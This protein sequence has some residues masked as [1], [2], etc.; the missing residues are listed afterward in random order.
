[1][2]FI[3]VIASALCLAAALP[4]EVAPYGIAALGFICLSPYFAVLSRSSSYKR[5]A[6]LGA[7]FGAL[8]H[9]FSSYWLYFFKGFA[10]WTLG[11]TSIAYALLHAIV[12]MYIRYFSLSDRGRTRPGLSILR[13][14][15]IAALWTIWEW[16]KSIGFLGYPWGLVAYAANDI[17]V[18]IQTADLFGVYGLSFLLALSNALIAELVFY[19]LSAK[20]E[21]KAAIFL[22]LR[23]ALVFFVILSWTILYGVY[24]LINPSPVIDQVPMVLVQ[25]NEDSWASGSELNALR[26]NQA[27]TRQGLALLAA[28]QTVLGEGK[29]Y[30]S[31][32]IALWSETTFQRPYADYR[33][34][35]RNKPAD[36]PFLPFLAEI[37]CPLLTGSP[38]VLDW[39]N[40]DATNSAL[41]LNS[42]GEILASYAKRHPVPFAEA[43]PFWEF[44]WMRDF[45]RKVV[46]LA[47]GW[48]MGSEATIMK[49]P[50]SSGKTLS[51]GV[52]ICF[53]D[54]FASVCADFIRAGADMLINLT[55]DA[56]SLTVSAETQHLVAA[57]F[58]CVEFRRTMV[59]ST[60]A[61]VSAVINAEGGIAASLPLFQ[62]AAL[63]VLVP[64]QKADANTVYLM[65]G[66]WFP[67]SLLAV[68]I[69]FRL[70]LTLRRRFRGKNRSGALT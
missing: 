32:D 4:N 51:F 68:L 25:P 41:L 29:A 42:S 1:M 31:A 49:I 37:G 67:A 14:F 24:S 30:P 39:E 17:P 55:N 34:Y 64:V 36:D 15:L 56:W 65:L 33:P 45:M 47:G 46:G 54:A 44:Q 48:V 40:Y 3:A 63:P 53:E 11:T 23:G 69:L 60:N 13:P 28:G 7:V 38:V 18:L 58:R 9:A 19:S 16:A 12:A 27:L 10:F 5:A 61:G 26:V 62:S 70:Y 57:R 59:R 22:W 6:T 43:I 50:T 20:K 35:F 52:P 21:L 66:D 2:D 8:S